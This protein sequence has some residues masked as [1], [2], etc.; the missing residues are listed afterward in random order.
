ML[1]VHYSRIYYPPIASYAYPKPV[2]VKFSD[3]AIPDV[4]IPT[5]LKQ[6][7]VRQP[8]AEGAILGRIKAKLQGLGSLQGQIVGI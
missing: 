7:G 1:V 2:V 6:P 8:L 5:S 4:E 3:I